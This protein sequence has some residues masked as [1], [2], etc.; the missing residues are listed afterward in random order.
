MSRTCLD[1]GMVVPLSQPDCP[2]C[3]ARLS[4]QTDGS[5]LHIDVAHQGETVALALSL[6]RS[7]LEEA[8]QTPAKALRVVVGGGRIREEVGSYLAYLLHTGEVSAYEQEAGNRGAYV[9]TLKRG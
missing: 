3:D 9:I 5:L 2:K 1:C 4:L 7:A 6:L 8:A